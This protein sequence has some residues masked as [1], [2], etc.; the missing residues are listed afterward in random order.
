MTGRPNQPVDGIGNL[1]ARLIK[2]TSSSESGRKSPSSASTARGAASIAALASAGRKGQ[3]G[4]SLDVL[5]VDGLFEYEGDCSVQLNLIETGQEAQVG[6]EGGKVTRAF[7]QAHVGQQQ[8]RA[9][10]VD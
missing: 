9:D 1:P 2:R 4:G 3:H 10:V 8:K 5:L 6:G 7:F